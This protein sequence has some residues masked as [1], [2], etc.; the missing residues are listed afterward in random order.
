MPYITIMQTPRT[1][2][3][4]LEEILKGEVNVDNISPVAHDVSGTVTRFYET[5][6]E[7]VIRRADIPSMIRLLEEFV[8]KHEALF[9]VKRSSLYDTFPIPKKSG[10]LRW[11]NAPHE[12]LM[13]ALR[14]LKSIFEDKMFALY[15]TAAFAYVKNRNTL[16][17]IK[18]HQAN[19]SKWFEKTDFS[20]FFGSTTIEFVLGMMNIIFPFSEIMKDE[21]G[22]QLL[23]KVLDLCFLNGGLPQGTPIS[24]MLTN[25]MMIPIDHALFNALRKKSFIYTRFAD[26]IQISSRYEFDPFAMVKEIDAVLLKFNAPFKIK[27]SK[28]RYGSSSGR[29]WNLGLMLN[30]NNTITVGYQ[31][32]K[33]FKAMCSNYIQ[34]KKH[35]IK[36]DLHDVQTL[37]GLKAYYKMV[38]KDYISYII[39]QLNKKYHVN[40][41]RMMRADLRGD[42]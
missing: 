26:D 10:G 13:E 38:E 3:I 5:I 40:L 35:G 34:D 9:N 36:W 1:H 21:K 7:E 17:A 8:K 32:K 2:Q 14:E 15:H 37:N 18:R 24:P 23:E 28:T 6:N 20:D 4:T 30:R 42:Q 12:P 41:V 33:R 25:L 29:N 22:Q 31:A 39:D 16:D 27:P 11:I 19:E